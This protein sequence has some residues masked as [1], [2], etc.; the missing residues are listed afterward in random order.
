MNII[1]QAGGRGTRLRYRGWNKPKCL[2]TVNGKPLMYHLFDKYP[3]A[4]FHIIGD[5]KYEILQKYLKINPPSVQNTLYRSHKKGTCAGMQW[6]LRSLNDQ[7][8]AVT[9]G[10]ILYNEVVDFSG[11]SPIIFKTSCYSSRYKC[12]GRK[13]VK[14]K[15]NVD[16]IAGIFY[17]P[18]KEYITG[19][20]SEGSFMTWTKD[21]VKDYVIREC[22]GIDELG[23]YDHYNKLLID[24]SKA[25][26]FNR[27]YFTEHE[28]HKECIVND[29][30]H[31]I[32]NEQ[33]WY[34]FMKH[35]GFKKIPNII[36]ENP[37]VLERVC[38][39][40][41]F[42]LPPDTAKKSVQSILKSLKEMHTISQIEC[43]EKE[44][45]LVYVNKT[46]DRLKRI[47]EILPFKD[48]EHIT[49]NGVKCKNVFYNE[50]YDIIEKIYLS[51]IVSKFC[52]IHGDPSASNIIMKTPIDPVFIDPRGYFY[53]KL[54]YGD[55]YYDFAK[56]YFSM[57]S[58]YDF[59][60]RKQFVLFYDE[61]SA[62]ILINNEKMSRNADKVFEKNFSETEMKNIKLINCLI[63]FGMSGYAIDDVDSIIAAHLIGLYNLE[64]T[65]G[66]TNE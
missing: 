7:P 32:K 9:W 17:F 38:G 11:K 27:L 21:N 33:N 34:R 64:K 39:S 14:E 52:S 24:G 43:D 53:N 8:V 36:S 54:I 58:G 22:T 13:I 40:H 4:H 62:E 61:H 37:Y 10:D 30:E 35:N 47:Y 2:M 45:R 63:W 55:R 60:N 6:V 65:L 41:P 51:L 59:Y 50:N 66:A 18:N 26:F 5:Y 57:V 20:D 19:V 23:D 42:E 12:Y 28:V 1:V 16:G 46:I 44:L 3:Q 48:K 56:L 15:T 29:Y 25:R 49:I 31:L